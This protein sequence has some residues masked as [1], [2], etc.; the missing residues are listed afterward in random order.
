VYKVYASSGYSGYLA[1]LIATGK[2]DE[3]KEL[4]AADLVLFAGGHDVSPELYGHR[5]SRFT[6]SY[7]RRDEEEVHDFL[8][9]K[10]AGIPMVGICRGMQFLTAVT[11][12]KLFQDVNGHAGPRHIMVTDKGEEFVVNSLHHQMC[13]PWHGQEEFKLLGWSKEK[14]SDIYLGE[15]VLVEGP[16]VEPE[17][18][19]WPGIKAFAV[20]WHPEMMYPTRD[21]VAIDW[22]TDHVEMLLNDE[23]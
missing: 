17:A 9:A 14:Q 8:A 4:L 18:I 15:D 13:D 21:S 20:Q 11:G 10:Q 1:P 7:P 16:P 3:T 23:L 22:Y 2:Y 19:Y 12:G 6:Y 5:K